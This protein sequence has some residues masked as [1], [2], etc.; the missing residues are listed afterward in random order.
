VGRAGLKNAVGKCISGDRAFGQN[1]LVQWRCA[2]EYSVCEC[3]VESDEAFVL[4]VDKIFGFDVCRYDGFDLCGCEEGL[5]GCV[6]RFE[7][8]Q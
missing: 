2:I 8:R 7:E 3:W 4:G 1:F 6:C 5:G